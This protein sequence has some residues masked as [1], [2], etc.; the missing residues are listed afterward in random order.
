MGSVT[1]PGEIAAAIEAV[2]PAAKIKI[3]VPGG[4]SIALPNVD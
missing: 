3:E 1:T 2:V 4:T